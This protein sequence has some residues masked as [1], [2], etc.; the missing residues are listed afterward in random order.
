[1]SQAQGYRAKLAMAY[2][3]SFGITPG[4][5]VGVILPIHSSK[6]IAKQTLITDKTIRGVR[7][8]APPGLGNIDVSGQVTVPVDEVNFG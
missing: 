2:E 6:I 7:D 8:V 1:M 3:S 5:P 4:S